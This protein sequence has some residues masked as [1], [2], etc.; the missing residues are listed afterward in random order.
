MFGFIVA[1]FGGI[2]LLVHALSQANE[3]ERDREQ[4]RR[5]GEEYYFAHDGKRR[6]SDNHKIARGSYGIID[7]TTGEY[8]VD[9]REL[10]RQ[11]ELKIEEE[12][13]IS[14]Q[15]A[16][17]KGENTYSWKKK[18]GSRSYDYKY[19]MR[20]VE[21]DM[22]IKSNSTEY[23]WYEGQKMMQHVHCSRYDSNG[24]KMEVYHHYIY[25]LYEEKNFGFYYPKRYTDEEIGHDNKRFTHP[26]YF[27]VPD[28]G[29]KIVTN[30]CKEYNIKI[31]VGWINIRP[32]NKIKWM[33]Q[34]CFKYG[35]PM[36]T[37]EEVEKACWEEHPVKWGKP[38]T[39][40]YY[41]N[42]FVDSLF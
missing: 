20:L 31:I 29:W 14:K 16:I 9:R 3:D 18:T 12:N 42:Q 34:Y 24:R 33:H 10:E 30:W 13:K 23:E 40:S 35:I 38:A 4:A 28:E 19:C 15:E 41:F 21:N 8:I 27:Q 39:D 37:W 22:P 6:V 11:A 32:I 25:Q 7:A 17:I 5:D 2:G 26:I 1:L 36:G